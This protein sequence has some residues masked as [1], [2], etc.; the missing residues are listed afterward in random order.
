MRQKAELLEF[1]QF[2]T[3][4]KFAGKA[5]SQKLQCMYDLKNM[6]INIIIVM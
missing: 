2:A 1:V 3:F 5:G 6:F 4:S